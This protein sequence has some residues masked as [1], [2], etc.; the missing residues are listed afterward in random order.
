MGADVKKITM[1]L[2][3]STIRTL[4]EKSLPGFLT[5]IAASTV[6]KLA[7]PQNEETSKSGQANT[8]RKGVLHC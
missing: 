7:T 5:T 8:L 6:H 1:N 4:P 2:A 3:I